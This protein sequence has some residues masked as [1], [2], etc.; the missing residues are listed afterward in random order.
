MRKT[1]E[2]YDKLLKRLSLILTKLY[3]GE[4]LTLRELAEEFNVSER[5][6]SRD[7]NER[8]SDF[9]I[10]AEKGKYKLRE[11]L[12][13]NQNLNFEDKLILKILNEISNSFSYEFAQKSQ[14][15]LSRL[16]S[17]EFNPFYSKL[18]L[19]NLEDKLT[20]ITLIEKAIQN[21]IIINFSY[22][23]NS[24]INLVEANPL[25]IANY[26]GLWYLIA[27]NKNILKSYYLRD[28]SDVKISN[29]NFVV[30]NK[31]EKLL[32][33]SIN[34]WFGDYQPFEVIIYIKPQFTKHFNRKKIN[35][36]QRVIKKYEDGAMEISF[37]ATTQMEVIPLIK[38]W[39]PY[40]K[41]IEP[42]ELVEIIKNDLRS[43]L[44]D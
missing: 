21:H 41:L 28:I 14:K 23:K 8:L 17:P 18:W 32:Q 10:Y 43:Y 22:Y 3:Q 16:E 33:N 15:L 38:S 4:S 40:I 19:E 30:T 29:Q 6:I 31:V 7:L 1:K 20:E 5:T 44:N 42:K 39:I 27:I 13:K 2:D 34:I 12:F 25:K 26:D 9:P 37:Y 35:P 36:T 11:Y 24:E